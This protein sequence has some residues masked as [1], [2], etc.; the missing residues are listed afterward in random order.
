MLWGSTGSGDMRGMLSKGST[1]CLRSILFC[2]ASSPSSNRT[3][4]RLTR[5][6]ELGCFPLNLSVEDA[7]D[8]QTGM[9]GSPETDI[10]DLRRE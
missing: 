2:S 9:R 5:T 3:I 7:L 8:S 4:I 1:E 10:Q 6:C